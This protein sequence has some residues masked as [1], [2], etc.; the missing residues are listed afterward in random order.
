M[1]SELDS[2]RLL[3]RY[4]IHAQNEV[5][6]NGDTKT[7]E[8]SGFR[9]LENIT[10][11]WLIVILINDLFGVSHPQLNTAE[12]S[13]IGTLPIGPWRDDGRISSELSETSS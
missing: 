5:N 1:S 9:I 4:G 11:N 7:P 13:C 10:N 2:E 12:S 6:L 8:I 3:Y